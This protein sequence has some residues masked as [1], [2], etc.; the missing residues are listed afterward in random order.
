MRQKKIVYFNFCTEFE[1]L[2]FVVCFNRA[3]RKGTDGGGL[4]AEL[5][6]YQEDT[7]KYDLE[8]ATA[9]GDTLYL[10]QGRDENGKRSLRSS[11]ASLLFGSS[12]EKLFRNVDNEKQLQKMIDEKM[13]TKEIL[14]TWSVKQHAGENGFDFD[15]GFLTEYDGYHSKP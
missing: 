2:R 15:T 5:A 3:D 8:K 4:I 10:L 9:A 1:T 13:S 11:R 14:N 12:E 6:V 7:L